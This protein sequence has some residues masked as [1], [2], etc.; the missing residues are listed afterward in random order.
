MR[1][2]A[3]LFTAALLISTTSP[4]HAG[5]CSAEIDGLQGRID[6][7]L[8]AAA[9]AGPEGT[10][11]AAAR[12]HREPTPESIAAAEAKLGDVSGKWVDEVGQAMA[13]ARTADIVGDKV[14][15][16]EALGIVRSAFNH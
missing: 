11:S 10:E 13:R 16:E 5:P 12:D 1:V 4:C 9:A 2:L 14:A 8:N 6:A 3:T 7:K 15:C